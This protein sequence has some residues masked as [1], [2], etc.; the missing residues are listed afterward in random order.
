[1][2]SKKISKSPKISQISQ[3]NLVSESR[4]TLKETYTGGEGQNPI[5]NT[6]LQSNELQGNISGTGKSHQNSRGT[7]IVIL[8]GAAPLM[9]APL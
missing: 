5:Q 7:V 9:E 8:A 2:I 3:V 6:V 1:M 4:G